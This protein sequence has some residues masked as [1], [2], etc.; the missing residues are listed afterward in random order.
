MFLTR[1]QLRRW[2]R[3][4]F[5]S[6]EQIEEGTRSAETWKTRVKTASSGNAAAL[7]PEEEGQVG[8][9]RGRGEWPLWREG[10]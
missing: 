10:P 2:P 9:S 3:R 7:S 1:G 8:N 6:A 4:R 5:S